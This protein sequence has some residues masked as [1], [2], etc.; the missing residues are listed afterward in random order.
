MSVVRENQEKNR[1]PDSRGGRF[2]I[3]ATV[4]FGLIPIAGVFFLRWS[5]VSVIVLFWAETLVIALFTLISVL[6][7]GV[8]WTGKVVLAG[9]ATAGIVILFSGAQYLFLFLAAAFSGEFHGRGGILTAS[10]LSAPTVLLGI[11]ACVVQNLVSF[12]PHSP[13]SKPS[14]P[15]T[16]GEGIFTRLIIQNMVIILA[17]GAAMISRKASSLPVA[18]LCGLKIWI[19]VSVMRPVRLKR[20]PDAEAP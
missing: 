3:P 8:R 12:F 17:F 16:G 6:R 13:G 19:D 1:V 10:V 7:R 5:A 11:L 18:V 20:K 9:S 14:P 2:G 4:I 15:G